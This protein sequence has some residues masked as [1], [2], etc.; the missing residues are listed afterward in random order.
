[1]M[2]AMIELFMKNQQST[3]TTLVQVEWSITGIIDQVDALE[4][5]L[6]PADQAKLVEESREDDNDQE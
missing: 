2:K 1:M 5:G 3:D 6:P 4:T